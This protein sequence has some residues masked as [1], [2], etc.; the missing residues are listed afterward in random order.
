[1]RTDE[2]IELV[3]RYSASL[4]LIEIALGSLLHAFHIPFSGS[5]LS[6][7]Q[8]FLLCRA[9]IEARDRNIGS[10]G[11]SISNVSAVLKSFAPA[12]KKLGPMLSLSMQ[13]L[14]FS[15]GEIVFGM[16]LL[17][18]MLGMVLLSLWTFLQPLVTYY[19]FFGNE[20]FLA[21]DALVKKTIP[22]T[23]LGWRE[24]SLILAGFL[25]LKIV[26][27]IFLTCLA[28]SR[29]GAECFQDRLLEMA[30]ERGNQTVRERLQCSSGAIHDSI[31]DLL[32]PLFLASFAVTAFF[33]VYSEDP[34]GARI[35]TLLRPLAVAFLFFYIS[36]R[37]SFE[38]VLERLQGT[39]AESFARSCRTA[40]RELRK[41]AP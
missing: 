5:F 39:K 16:N 23:G 41:L 4:S 1:M 14:F 31:R 24:L 36:R 40:L 38:A 13:G 29:K 11:Y 10:V 25:C 37:I 21:L 27:A 30:A 2:R 6:L 28:C 33:L 8:G 3:G 22:W 15:L 18:W 19:L 20:L 34:M 26:T 32:S 9:S 7:N 17:G 35:W 12:G